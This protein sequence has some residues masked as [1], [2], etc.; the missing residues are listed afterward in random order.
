MGLLIDVIY[1]LLFAVF[2]SVAIAASFGL[3]RKHK[4]YIGH[5]RIDYRNPSSGGRSYYI[6][7]DTKTKTLDYFTSLLSLKAVKYAPMVYDIASFSDDKKN[8]NLIRSPT[9][10]KGDNLDVPEGRSLNSQAACANYASLMSNSV[11]NVME[12]YD[13]CKKADFR[14]G[15]MVSWIPKKKNS[16]ETIAKIMRISYDGIAIAYPN[17]EYQSNIQGNKS[18]DGIPK[19]LNKVFD[20]ENYKELKQTMSLIDKKN[21]DPI[22]Y[23]NFFTGEWVMVTG[24]IRKV[25]DANVITI[26]TKQAIA[27]SIS[28]TNE[29]V[30]D[31]SGFLEKH[32][33]LIIG[34]LILTFTGLTA[35]FVFYGANSWQT[36]MTADITAY[37]A[38]L[39][40]GH[41][42]AIATT[43]TIAPV[44]NATPTIT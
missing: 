27:Q 5:L 17:P 19:L 31:R 20:F 18:V 10:K 44:P 33:G 41:A 30:L 6:V 25:E 13:I 2:L 42:G 21:L 39:G 15:E 23:N 28:N 29:F 8:V 22:G 16:S 3:W 35:M 26:P 9:G 11:T 12:F 24:G 34:L 43:T 38:Q 4:A 36:G 37:A 40:L 1:V 32:S 7:P 14:V